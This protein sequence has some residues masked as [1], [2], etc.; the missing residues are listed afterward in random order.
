MSLS[1]DE[2][3]KEYKRRCTEARKH[4]ID[5]SDEKIKVIVKRD[6]PRMES[7]EYES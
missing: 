2:W 6:M 7:N 5:W 3:W 4:H 1:R